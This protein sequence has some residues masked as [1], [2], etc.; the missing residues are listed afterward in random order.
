LAEI[1]SFE[2]TSYLSE[3]IDYVFFHA[4]MTTGCFTRYL[5]R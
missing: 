5:G 1:C 3:A 4:I 2:T